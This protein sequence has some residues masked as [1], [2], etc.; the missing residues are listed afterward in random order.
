MKKFLR[1]WLILALL[2][3]AASFFFPEGM[4]QV[5]G[6]A[7]GLAIYPYACLLAILAAYPQRARQR[8]GQSQSVSLT[9]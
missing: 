5:F 9:A 4:R 7:N 2:T 6:Y 3:L 8:R 1:N